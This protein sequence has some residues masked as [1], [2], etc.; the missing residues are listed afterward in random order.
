[1]S[2]SLS[3]ALSGLTAASRA[4]EVVS[5]N[6]AN[7]LTKGYGRRTLDLLARNVGTTGQG[8]TVNGVTR[9]INQTLLSDRRIADAGA[10][11]RDLRLAFLSRLEGILGS[12][13]GDGALGTDIAKLDAA[14]VSAAS[15]PEAQAR[16]GA[17]L[18]AARALSGTLAAAGTDV[19]VA[20]ADA[21]RRI[22]SE[23]DRVNMSLR[24]VAEMNAQ[25]RAVTSAGG[26][27]SALMDQR[28]A[29]V[30][31]IAEIVPLREM[32]RDQG[33]IALFTTGGAMLLD[34]RPATLGF[35]VSGTITADMT[36]ASGA[37]SSLTLNGQTVTASGNA[38]LVAGGSLAAHFAVRDDLAV[39][40][41]LRLDAMARDLVERFQDPA[42]DPT[43]Q[44]GAAGLFTDAGT[45]F[46]ATNEPGLAQ[47][48]QV[49]A[50]VD[51]ARG[52]ALWRLRDGIGAAVP[53]PT[54]NSTLLNALQSALTTR[55]DPVS[56]DFT[57]GARSFS[58]LASDVLSVVSAARLTADAEVSFSSSRADT[59]RAL[60]LEQGVDTDQELQNLL[61]IEQAY[62]ANARV[63][64]TVDDMIQTLL[65]I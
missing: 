30:D 14:L 25:V 7:S 11:D 1:M 9:N 34:G 62:S 51:P 63:M 32:S 23:V 18:D 49:N 24:Q 13:D 40:A 53:G 50:L 59:L 4:A 5:S 45:A 48:L 3:S 21:D 15:R 19:Q 36:L 54:G 61:Q 2:A 58:G 39:S 46:L 37:L 52:G 8:V 41:Q 26:D 57:P 65:G 64:Q 33:E 22:G 6:V 42:V 44:A 17:V 55:R 27:P 38:S 35:G 12:G 47:R 31:G 60:E 56:G 28:Q 16:L 43:L 10:A 20:R 29:L